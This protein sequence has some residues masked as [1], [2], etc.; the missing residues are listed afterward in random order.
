MSIPEEIGRNITFLRSVAKVSRE[1]LSLEADVSQS[2]LY[3]IEHGKGNPTVEILA[4]IANALDFPFEILF[5]C[6]LPARYAYLVAAQEYVDTPVTIPELIF[7]VGALNQ[8][9]SQKGNI[10]LEELL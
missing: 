8:L 4:K 9:R 1:W 10:T 3:E 5:A 2:R 7:L 6:D